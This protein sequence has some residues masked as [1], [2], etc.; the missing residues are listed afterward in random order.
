MVSVRTPG[1]LP[2]GIAPAG[3]RRYI[4]VVESNGEVAHDAKLR[5]RRVEELVIHAVGQER[6]EAVHAGHP[7]KKL[8][9]RRRK[10]VLPE[11]DL[12]RLADRIEA[13]FG[14]EA[15]D[16][17]AGTIAHEAAL[18]SSPVRSSLASDSDTRSRAATRFSREFA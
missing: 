12:A 16:E 6:E 2:A 7:T 18:T 10:L 4:D 15:G 17:D 1:V 8:V 13:G 11:I 5:T 3:Q 14:D 9:T